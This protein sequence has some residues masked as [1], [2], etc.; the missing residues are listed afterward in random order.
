MTS[1]VLDFTL[2]VRNSTIEFSLGLSEIIAC[3]WGDVNYAII[4]INIINI[5]AIL[6]LCYNFLDRNVG[7]GTTSTVRRIEEAR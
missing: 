4:I 5:D 2:S 6:P 3:A 7:A 1:R